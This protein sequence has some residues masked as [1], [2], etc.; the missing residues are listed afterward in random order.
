MVIKWIMIFFALGV[1]VNC[2]QRPVD[3]RDVN[4]KKESYH[5]AYRNRPVFTPDSSKWDSLYLRNKQYYDQLVSCVYSIRENVVVIAHP[6]IRKDTL[7]IHI[8]SLGESVNDSLELFL[9]DIESN[10]GK[11]KLKRDIME[12]Q[13]ED[14]GY[15]YMLVYS[16]DFVLYINKDKLFA[17]EPNCGEFRC[18]SHF[19]D[20]IRNCAEQIGVPVRFIQIDPY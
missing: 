12:E 11:I 14:D 15:V 18:E 7:K 2:A 1:I 20:R 8:S 6:S 17:V 5:E 19:V 13:A 10:L 3:I 9:Y 4:K 16:E